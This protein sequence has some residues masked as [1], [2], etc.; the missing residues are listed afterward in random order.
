MGAEPT[1]ERFRVAFGCPEGASQESPKRR[2]ACFAHDTTNRT[3]DRGGTVVRRDESGRLRIQ[4]RHRPS[5]TLLGYLVPGPAG[6]GGFTEVDWDWTVCHRY[7]LVHRGMPPQ[8][9][10]M[11][12]EDGWYGG[13]PHYRTVA[14]EN[15][16]ATC[17][18]LGCP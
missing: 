5:R 2:A 11:T 15:T 1:R 9:V 14:G 6:P 10:G 17:Q 18:F 13:H 7:N 12:A 8:V 3:A 16:N 4:R